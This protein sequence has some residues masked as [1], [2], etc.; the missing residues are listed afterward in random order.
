VMGGDD[1]EEEFEE[2][3][4]D[5]DQDSIMYDESDASPLIKAILQNDR[6][7]VASLLQSGSIVL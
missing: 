6:S 1:D 2:E 4:S 3:E 5:K 7:Q